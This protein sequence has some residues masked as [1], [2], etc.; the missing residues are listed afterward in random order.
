MQAGKILFQVVRMIFNEIGLQIVDKVFKNE[1]I[2]R[3]QKVKNSRNPIVT[4]VMK[5]GRKIL[6]NWEG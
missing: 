5:G 2:S 4:S 3:N 6:A 1:F